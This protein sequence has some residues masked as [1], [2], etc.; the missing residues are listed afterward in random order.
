[1]TQKAPGRS[2]TGPPT[3]TQTAHSGHQGIRLTLA[4]RNWGLTLPRARAGTYE[5][6]THSRWHSKFTEGPNLSEALSGRDNALNFIR[7]LLAAAVIFD[8]AWAVGGYEDGPAFG[9]SGWAVNGFFAISGYLIAGSRMRLSAREYLVNRVARIFPAYWTVLIITAFAFAP[10]GA[11]VGG[12]NWQFDSA[13]SYIVKNAGLYIFQWSIEDTLP[14]VP[15]PYSWNGS[16][17]TLFYEFVAYIAAAALLGTRWARRY[18]LIVVSLALLVVIVGQ[19]LAHG[20]LEVTTNLYLNMLR[21]S[22]FFLAGMLVHFLAPRLKLNAAT[23]MGASLLLGTL[24][25]VGAADWFGQ[26]PLTVILL[27]LG[28]RLPVRIGSKNDVSYGLYIWAFP[29]QQLIAIFGLLWLGPFWTAVLALLLTLPLAWLSWI[30]VERPS[31]E[32]RK[33]VPKKLLGKR[34]TEIARWTV[35]EQRK[36]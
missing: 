9:I 8:H 34:P 17:W 29:I 30:Y 22:A 31:M 4:G 24:F 23:L 16:L 25:Y 28:G 2:I 21:L 36:L 10:L 3:E 15:Y 14:N 11:W 27:W 6:A 7:L 5:R 20:P 35:P 26:L 12:G 33:R 13:L 32:L 18:A 19:P 1:M